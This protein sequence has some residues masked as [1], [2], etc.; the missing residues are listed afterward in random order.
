MLLGIRQVG[1]WL[2]GQPED[3]AALGN[4]VLEGA[5]GL[6]SSSDVVVDELAN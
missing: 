1:N 6:T 4:I 3:I 2:V 5:R